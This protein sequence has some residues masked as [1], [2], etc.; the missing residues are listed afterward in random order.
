MRLAEIKGN[1]TATV[2]HSCFDGQRLL[3]AQ[4]VNEDGTDAG[5]PQ[6]VL[7]PYGAAIGQRVLIT[8][9]GKEARD[10]VG[11]K[12]SPARWMVMGIVDPEGALNL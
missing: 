6:V 11:C 9:D 7:D 5:S 8:S 1:V 12:R 4:P 2:R 3:I 10:Y